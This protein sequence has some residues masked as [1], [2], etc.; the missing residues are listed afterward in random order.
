MNSVFQI[1]VPGGGGATPGGSDT[2]VQFNDGGSALGGSSKLTFNKTSGL[3][4]HNGLKVWTSSG[5]IADDASLTLPAITNG[6]RGSIQVGNLLAYAEFLVDDDGDVTLLLN[7]D[8]V[9]AG[10]DTDGKLCIGTAATQEPLLI[11]NR[12]GGGASKNFNL[13]LWYN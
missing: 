2:E 13:I 3:L 8:N 7:S 6:A 9:V 1:P 5:Q 12:L 4:T 10:A 11:K